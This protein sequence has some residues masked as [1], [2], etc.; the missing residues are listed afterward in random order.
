MFKTIKNLL[1]S[2]LEKNRERETLSSDSEAILG[3]IYQDKLGNRRGQQT[4]VSAVA[5]MDPED[6]SAQEYIIDTLSR[7]MPRVRAR[8]YV[9][10]EPGIV[11]N[12]AG[13]ALDI[14][15]DKVSVD[16]A[17]ILLTEVQKAALEINGRYRR[18]PSD[19]PLAGLKTPVL[20]IRTKNNGQRLVDGHKRINRLLEISD[21]PEELRVPAIIVEESDWQRY[22]V[23][24]AVSE[25]A[26]NN[27]EAPQRQVIADWQIGRGLPFAKNPDLFLGGDLLQPVEYDPL[28][29][30]VTATVAE[31]RVKDAIALTVVRLKAL[32][33]RKEIQANKK[34]RCALLK[35]R[36]G[37]D[38]SG[39]IARDFD[40]I[41]RLAVGED[42]RFQPKLQW[43]HLE[44]NI[45]PKVKYERFGYLKK[46]SMLLNFRH[47]VDKQQPHE[48]FSREAGMYEQIMLLL[49]ALVRIRT[50]ESF[51]AVAG[52]AIDQKVG[53][54]T[55][56]KGSFKSAY[57]TL[58]S[59]DFKAATG[60]DAGQ[61]VCLVCE[62][63]G[64][65]LVDC[66][67]EF[68]PFRE[69]IQ[70]AAHFRDFV[71]RGSLN[72]GT[73]VLDPIPEWMAMYV[74]QRF[75]I[76]REGGDMLSKHWDQTLAILDRLGIPAERL[77]YIAIISYLSFPENR[78][79]VTMRWY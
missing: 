23:S 11:L 52:R 28:G 58:K 30:G 12:V 6:P 59:K 15:K 5:L 13:L 18:L 65:S 67:Y 2:L 56:T 48:R 36:L 9:L 60:M 22:V 77:K 45:V 50:F 68:A 78:R 32:Q 40:D 29:G 54:N 70:I 39:S 35:E 20:L 31:N 8:E 24:K 75:S 53:L 76:S 73:H 41:V 63:V 71:T 37:A 62:L 16:R 10:V 66:Y 61:Y 46:S 69:M 3:R 51:Q 42:L 38:F 33:R 1:N 49:R 34:T 7:L 43:D 19:A 21:K 79:Q 64:D 72:P 74:L 55:D 26:D 4:Y 17:D 47:D 44:R 14:S 57:R 27:I 25:D